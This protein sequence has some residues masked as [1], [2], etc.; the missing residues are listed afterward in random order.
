MGRVEDERLLS[1]GELAR[2]SG[3]ATSALRFWEAEGLVTPTERT[4][5]G[6]RRYDAEAVARVRFVLRAQALGLSLDEVRE[7]LRAADGEG[8]PAVREHLR[9]LLAHKLAQTRSQVKELDGFA[10]Q[11][12][13]VW[14]RLGEAGPCECH[15]LG[16]CSCL[17][18]S[19]QA[20]GH[21]RLLADLEVI[22]KGVCGCGA[23]CGCAAAAPAGTARSQA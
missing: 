19:V 13:R 23:D 10:A 1:I 14:I 2:R 18:P 6:Y 17:P 7:L 8:E 22:S 21:R 5:S 3:I 12:E 15:H 4:A 16:E 9:H 20:T 11:L